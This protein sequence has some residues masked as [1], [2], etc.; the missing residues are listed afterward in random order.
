[1]VCAGTVSPVVS[2]TPSA[3]ASSIDCS[4]RTSTSRDRNTSVA[5]RESRSSSSGNTLGARSSSIQRIGWS[6]SRGCRRPSAVVNSGPWA[7]TSVP[8]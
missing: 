4:V 6:R 3:V 7:A 5:V 1:M 8:V 2:R